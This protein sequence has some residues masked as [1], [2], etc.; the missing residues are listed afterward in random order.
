MDTGGEPEIATVPLSG[1]SAAL[2][3][4]AF[5]EYW[6]R[7]WDSYSSSGVLALLVCTA[8]HP[9]ITRRHCSKFSVPASS[10]VDMNVTKQQYSKLSGRRAV[11]VD[12]IYR[13]TRSRYFRTYMATR[14]YT[15]ISGTRMRQ[16]RGKWYIHTCVPWLQKASDSVPHSPLLDK[17]KL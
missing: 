10:L 13:N 6:G 4:C 9:K 7:A 12:S 1:V 2:L 11:V 15:P 5:M 16:T 3:V 14:E 17:L 8:L